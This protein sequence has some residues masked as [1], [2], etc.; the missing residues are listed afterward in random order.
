[1]PT[2][3]KL[4]H[5]LGTP[6]LASDARF[7]STSDRSPISTR[8]AAALEATLVAHSAPEW[9]DRLQHAGV[10]C[11]VV[12]T[13]AQ[14]ADDPQTA[15]RNMILRAGGIRVPGNPDQDEHAA[16]PAGAPS[17]PPALDADGAAHSARVR[18]AAARRPQWLSA[19][20]SS[21]S[22]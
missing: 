20:R 2:F 12:N 10:A 17:P 21:G 15:A 4:C 3:G 13:V 14:A 5:A 16:R 9:V 22:A 8:C 19:S 7:A 6:E 11:G 18:C 1:M